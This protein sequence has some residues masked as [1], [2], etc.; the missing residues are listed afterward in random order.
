LSIIKNTQITLLTIF[1]GLGL[2]TAWG[3]GCPVNTTVTLTNNAQ[4]GVIGNNSVICLTAGTRTNLLNLNG[5]NNLTLWIAAG[6]NF[7]ANVALGN[8]RINNYGTMRIPTLTVVN[9][10]SL[11]I[12]DGLSVTIENNV[13]LNG[14]AQLSIVNSTNL[15][16]KP[17]L[18]INQGI[19]IGNGVLDIGSNT[20]VN[21]SED[22]EKS[23]EATIDISG[24]YNGRSIIAPTGAAGNRF[25][26]SDDSEI[27]LTG[28]FIVN[29]YPLITSGN[30]QVTVDG[31]F[32][33]TE[34]EASSAVFEDY[35]TLLVLGI[36]NVENNLIFNG[37]SK[38]TFEGNVDIASRE[39][40]LLS[41]NGNGDVLIT[42][43]LA[44]RQ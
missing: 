11:V 30:S 37:N 31:E 6:A 35:S 24:E 17:S 42:G 12:F 43:D 40:A 15:T 21:V 13:T 44:K 8:G 2:T 5:W 16:P 27:N 34:N 32:Y 20:I 36:S 39:A 28:D 14:G 7:N 10:P 3:Q 9:G 23:Y 1:L 29:G 4:V 22:L 26:L 41:V 25:N 19:T 33:T 18:N 38:A